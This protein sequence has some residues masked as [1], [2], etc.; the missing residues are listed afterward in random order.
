M[1][2]FIKEFPWYNFIFFTI[3]LIAILSRDGNYEFQFN[4]VQKTDY[5]KITK[6]LD[7][8]FSPLIFSISIICTILLRKFVRKQKGIKKEKKDHK[9]DRVSDGCIFY[10]FMIPIFLIAFAWILNTFTYK[11]EFEKD[12]AISKN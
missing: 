11:I 3:A 2:S 9:T 8:Y 5:I 4:I 12:K 10:F 1:K 7:A 6:D